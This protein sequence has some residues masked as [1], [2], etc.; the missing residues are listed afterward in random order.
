MGIEEIVAAQKKFRETRITWRQFFRKKFHEGLLGFVPVVGQIP[1]K[2][3]ILMGMLY[4]FLLIAV[5]LILFTTGYFASRDE[6]YLSPAT[7][8]IADAYCELLPVENTGKF[9]AT[10]GGIWQRSSGFIYSEAA[11]LLSLFG[12]STDRNTYRAFMGEVYSDLTARGAEANN[13]DLTHNL[14]YWMGWSHP[15]PTRKSN[16]IS[17]YGDPLVLFNRDIAIFTVSNMS[18]DCNAVSSSQFISSTG[19]LTAAYNIQQFSATPYCSRIMNPGLLGYDSLSRP[20]QFVVDFDV[21][22]FVASMAVNLGQNNFSN[23]VEIAAFRRTVVDGLGVPYNISRYY[24]PKFPGMRQIG[25]ISSVTP[26]VCIFRKGSMAAIPFFHHVGANTSY[27][28]KCD[29]ATYRSAVNSNPL[30][31]CNAFRFLA[32]FMFWNLGAGTGIPEILASVDIKTLHAASYRAAFITSTYGRNSPYKGLFQTRAFRQAAFNFCVVPAIGP[33]SIAEF[34]LY[35]TV[36][37]LW[38]ISPDY[39]QLGSGACRNSITPPED[40]W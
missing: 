34:S 36:N 38:T 14:L 20:A 18:Y 6:V 35:D 4:L 39:L 25:C 2:L 3:R 13:S 30:H 11:L 22:A 26:H 33:C 40:A 16:R 37:A 5:F 31:N 32:G 27:P 7:G 28:T 1:P 29:C 17:L 23:L 19:I 9:L 12:Y 24:D 8:D 15:D 21:R 10:F